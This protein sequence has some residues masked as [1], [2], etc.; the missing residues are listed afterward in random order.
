MTP[1]RRLELRRATKVAAEKVS[2]ETTAQEALSIY[3]AILERGTSS[4]AEDDT[5]LSGT[6]HLIKA[7]WD[8]LM[9]MAEAAAAALTSDEEGADAPT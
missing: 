5:A 6:L 9:G 7:E 1:E 8:L 4:S 3:E 2:L